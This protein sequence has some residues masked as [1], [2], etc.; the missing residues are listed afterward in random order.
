MNNWW[1]AQTIAEDLRRELLDE[2]ERHRLTS[3]VRRSSL[4]GR[5]PLIATAAVVSLTV[6]LTFIWSIT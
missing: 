5:R 3:A 6:T 2:L 4:L 1:I